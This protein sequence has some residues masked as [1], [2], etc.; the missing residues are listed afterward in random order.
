MVDLKCRGRPDASAT[1]LLFVEHRQSFA[2]ERTVPIP[3]AN[4]LRI[5][6]TLSAPTGTITVPSGRKG[7]KPSFPER[8]LSRAQF[9]LPGA[10]ALCMVSSV[11]WNAG[12]RAQL[13]TGESEPALPRFPNGIQAGASLPAPFT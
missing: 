13:P 2:L 1:I 3:V 5:G 9:R 7:E 8:Y 6:S 12:R 11:N 10:T 4:L